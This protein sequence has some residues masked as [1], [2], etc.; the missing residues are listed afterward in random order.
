[1][2]IS[3]I[4]AIDQSAGIGKDGGVPWRLRSDMKW[5]KKTTMGHHV[6]MGRK[7]F[8]SIGMALPGRTNIILSR[9]LDYPAQGILVVDSLEAALKIAEQNGDDEAFI[10]GGGEIFAQSLPLADRLYITHVHADFDCDVFFPPINP[11]LWRLV[12]S[13]SYSQSAHDQTP[14][15]IQIF[16]QKR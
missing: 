14:F 10:I 13:E 4:A 2:I 1:M 12:S 3:L 6:I 9:N 11:D 15:T 8:E 5:F 16:E 7:T